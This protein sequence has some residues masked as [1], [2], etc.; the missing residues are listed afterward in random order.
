M[1]DGFSN[2]Q[3]N[4]LHVQ[5]PSPTNS[6]DQICARLQE[7]HTS[8]TIS[9]QYEAISNMTDEA[10]MIRLGENIN[11]FITGKDDY[12]DK[13]LELH[14]HNA[15]HHSKGI[16]KTELDDMDVSEVPNKSAASMYSKNNNMNKMKPRNTTHYNSWH[17]TDMI[18]AIKAVQTKN[19]SMTAA[20]KKYGIPRTT[21]RHY[22]NDGTNKE[23]KRVGFFLPKDQEIALVEY[24]LSHQDLSEKQ[25][26]KCIFDHAKHLCD[27]SPTNGEEERRIV[28]TPA[29]IRRFVYR[30]KKLHRLFP[31][32][33]SKFEHPLH[34][35]RKTSKDSSNE[36]FPQ[37]H[38]PYNVVTSSTSYKKATMVADDVVNKRKIS[39]IYFPTTTTTTTTTTNND[40]SKTSPLA[41]NN[42]Y[43]VSSK[44]ENE[45]SPLSSGISRGAESRKSLS[46][47]YASSEA[48]PPQK[49]HYQRSLSSSLNSVHTND[50]IFEPWSNDMGRDNKFRVENR[51]ERRNLYNGPPSRSM[52]RCPTSPDLDLDNGCSRSFILPQLYE[53][54]R[55]KKDFFENPLSYSAERFEQYNGLHRQRFSPL[56]IPEERTSF[57]PPNVCN[58]LEIRVMSRSLE[59][60]EHD[61]GKDYVQLFSERYSR[62][63]SLERLY[64]KWV[65]LK[66]S[67]E[68][69]EGSHYR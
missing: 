54:S 10:T 13:L 22:L 45:H 36:D 64:C 2:F 12:D 65:S 29:W 43:E 18:H 7:S 57:S 27:T 62:N 21:L 61:L 15:E 16:V 40:N 28:P 4:K 44:E 53:P 30:Q 20:A 51:R 67:V 31:T 68:V 52:P 24:A 1:T 32:L 63:R 47:E 25:L 3:V 14:H 33:L 6:I 37:D 69:R 59:R 38:D 41:H 5:Q 60:M 35:G 26:Y 11:T 8:T 46:E 56:F 55:E 39:S 23:A 34:G 19:L 42:M 9:Q 66:S 50:G 58:D 48:S 17:Y 49:H